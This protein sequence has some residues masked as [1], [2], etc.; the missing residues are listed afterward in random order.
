MNL[1]EYA[2][3]QASEVYGVNV[4]DIRAI[5]V[6]FRIVWKRRNTVEGYPRKRENREFLKNHAEYLR[7][8]KTKNSMAYERALLL[9]LR[10]ACF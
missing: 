3:S 8:V 1:F 4:V 5:I 9:S 6:G 10:E 2:E 7:S